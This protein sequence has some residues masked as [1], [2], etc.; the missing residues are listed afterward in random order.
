[1][2]DQ[3]RVGQ[4]F[5]AISNLGRG[6]RGQVADSLV[7]NN[8]GNADQFREFLGATG[9]SPEQ[10]FG[11][12]ISG[13]G[14]GQFSVVETV[15]SAR[16]IDRIFGTNFAGSDQISRVAAL[17][18]EGGVDRLVNGSEFDA[19]NPNR[20]DFLDE[21]GNPNSI[22][23]SPLIQNLASITTDT[24]SNSIE[25]EPSSEG[26]EVTAERSNLLDSFNRVQSGNSLTPDSPV[27]DIIF[28]LDILTNQI[29]QQ[30]GDPNQDE[31]VQRAEELIRLIDEEGI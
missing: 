13:F 11:G 17:V 12:L 9:A 4:V 22:S 3:Q 6:G 23:D 10:L 29:R 8:Q 25:S 15:E 31:A 24:Q 19:N 14:D 16:S 27:N 18:E 28:S 5:A 26:Q 2:L 20:E 21:D 1:M 7:L 30:G